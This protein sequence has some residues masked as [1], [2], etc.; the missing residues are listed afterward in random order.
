MSCSWGDTGPFSK[1]LHHVAFPQKRTGATDSHEDQEALRRTLWPA[2]FCP[3]FLQTRNTCDT[4]PSHLLI[5]QPP[6]Q[7]RGV[8]PSEQGT[9]LKTALANVRVRVGHV[10]GWIRCRFGSSPVTSASGCPTGLLVHLS[11]G[12]DK[13]LG[14]PL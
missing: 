14:V 13:L 2:P 9:L 10:T 6:G 4:Q 7:I 11:S 8:S 1:G 3:S 5:N 12:T